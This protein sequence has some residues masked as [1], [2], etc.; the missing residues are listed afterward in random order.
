MVSRENVVIPREVQ[1][2]KLYEISRCEGERI[3]VTAGV[4]VII[5]RAHTGTHPFMPDPIPV[6][7]LIDFLKAVPP[8]HLLPAPALEEVSRTI[9]I[10]YFPKGE[11]ILR[12]ENPPVQFLYVIRS[13]GVRILFSEKAGEEKVYDFRDDGDFF[14]LISV[15]SGNP[16]PFTVVAEEDT[17]C[18]L[19]RK[20]VLQRLFDLCPDILL[21]FTIGPSKGYKQFCSEVTTPNPSEKGRT[22]G[23][24]GP[25]TAG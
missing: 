7:K 18:Y 8:F 6:P 14:G 17:L 4:N 22:G 24:S 1:P 5:A 19:I 16:S 23:R 2:K 25:F 21:Y 9:V 11:I 3:C 20:E 10:E 13:G 15:L 12:P